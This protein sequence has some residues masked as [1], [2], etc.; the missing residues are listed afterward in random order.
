MNE[1]TATLFRY[2]ERGKQSLPLLLILHDSFF[3]NIIVKILLH[4]A[5]CKAPLIC[6]NLLFIP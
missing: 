5:F 6:H 3:F 4:P 2:S 1:F